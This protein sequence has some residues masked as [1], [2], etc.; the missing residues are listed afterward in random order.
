[1][2]EENTPYTITTNPQLS[3][4]SP[5]GIPQLLGDNANEPQRTQRN[6]TARG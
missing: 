4:Y 3:G 5:L 2:D 1:M 6:S